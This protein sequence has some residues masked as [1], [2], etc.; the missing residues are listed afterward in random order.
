MYCWLNK[1]EQCLLRQD[2]VCDMTVIRAVRRKKL[3]GS[4]SKQLNIV[5]VKLKYCLIDN[6]RFNVNALAITTLFYP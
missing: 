3:R 2:V 1:Y 6:I 4:N 5:N